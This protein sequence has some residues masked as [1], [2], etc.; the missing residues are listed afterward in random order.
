MAVLRIQV[1]GLDPAGPRQFVFA[2]SPVRIGRN[3]LNDLPLVSP[4]VSQ[5]HSLV[6][7]DRGAIRYLDLGSTNGTTQNGKRLEAS[8]PTPVKPG[9]KLSIGPLVMVFQV[10]ADRPAASPKVD[11]TGTTVDPDATRTLRLAQSAVDKVQPAYDAYAAATGVLLDELRKTLNGRDSRLQEMIF[12]LLEQRCSAIKRDP[13]YQKL[14]AEAAPD[15]ATAGAYVGSVTELASELGIK[16]SDEHAILQRIREILPAFCASF[17]ELRKGFA[18]F[19]R[20]L[21]VNTFREETPLVTADEAQD[22]LRYLFETDASA[23]EQLNGAFA[24]MMI[25]Q[26]ALLS[27]LMEGVRGLIRRFGPDGLIQS[28]LRNPGHLGPFTVRKS[29][30]P[31]S[32]FVR[33]RRFLETY[34]S[35]MADEHQLSSVLFGRE[36]ARSYGLARGSAR[37]T[38]A[39]AQPLPA[40]RSTSTKPSTTR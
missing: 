40:T 6:Q 12:L 28:L 31:F 9:E 19:G 18:E 16:A 14:K 32:V 2:H 10:G 1:S 30:W 38:G 5:W 39:P 23:V 3:R 26:V 8:V 17:V 29:F 11:P 25:H 33:W 34:D 4:Y 20:E 13:G 36:F 7:F 35:L 27:G 15:A 24:D 37:P 21:S 22:V